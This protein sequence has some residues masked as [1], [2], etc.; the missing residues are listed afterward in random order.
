MPTLDERIRTIDNAI[1]RYLD[2]LDNNDS[3]RAVISQDILTQLRKLTEH[4]MLKFY[5]NGNDIG[6][7][8]DN[9]EKAAEY[10]QSDGVLKVLY[11]FRNYLEIVTAYLTLDEE[12]C[13][14][15]MLKYYDYLLEIKN[16][17]Y[18]NFN[19]VI[20]HNLDKFPLNQDTALLEYYTKIAEKI[21]LYPSFTPTANDK[22]YIQKLKPFF[23]NGRRYY[24]VTFTPA[25]DKVSKS[26]RVIAFTSLP[27]TSNYASKF[28]LIEEHIEILGKTMPI[29][30]ITGWEVSIRDCEF[31]NFGS[32][33]T[34]VT[35]KISY[36]EQ[37]EV[38]SYLTR[39]GYSLTEIIDF[40]DAAYQNLINSWRANLRNDRFI[41]I[42]T[43]CR[44]IIRSERPGQNVLRYLLYCMNN[45]I[46]KDQRSGSPND[47][48]SNLYLPNGCRP[49]DRMPFVQS[50]LNHN[51]R[52]G[53]L[54]E[55]IKIFSLPFPNWHIM[56]ML[57]LLQ[58]HTTTDCGTDI[59]KEVRLLSIMALL[60][61]TNINLIPAI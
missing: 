59:V 36:P 1:C 54:F 52:L 29:L 42:L 46:I 56:V 12:N 10:S 41:Q 9:I 37:K 58:R 26:R 30:I 50:P 39:N 11:R 14:R 3:T 34:G 17:V 20:L 53:A 40:S 31:K 49:F 32:L 6:I 28:K 44:E 38:C 7:T 18:Y 57:L 43:K 4:L 22:Y 21:M 45:T 19:T 61:S 55:A 27:V 51:P 35:Q 23:I 15:L 2:S 16:I 25:T 60:T 5:A 24:E 13:E 47:A 8:A 48:I 33:L